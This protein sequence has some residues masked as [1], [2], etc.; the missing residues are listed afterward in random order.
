MLLFY[1][2]YHRSY[3]LHIEHT[4][5]YAARRERKI[6]KERRDN[7]EDTHKRGDIYGCRHTDV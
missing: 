5:I 3:H 1:F 4:F 7:G 6:E 2:S